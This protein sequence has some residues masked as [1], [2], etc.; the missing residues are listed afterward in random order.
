MNL[1]PFYFKKM[2]MQIQSANGHRFVSAALSSH[3]FKVVL[4]SVGYGMPC[5]ECDVSTDLHEH[6]LK[7][8]CMCCF[9][10]I[11]WPSSIWEN[12]IICWD[13]FKTVNTVRV[14]NLCW[15]LVFALVSGWTNL[16]SNCRWLMG[17]QF[18]YLCAYSY[19]RIDYWNM[20]NMDII[21]CNKTLQS[22]LNPD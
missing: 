18:E 19:Q 22:I 21:M 14:S 1:T 3:R 15:S 11:S 9:R 5:M 12:G 4:Y 20:H 2:H 16:W 10:G 6:K 8:L 7:Y 13:D 17:S